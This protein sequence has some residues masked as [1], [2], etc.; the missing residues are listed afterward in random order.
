MVTRRGHS[1]FVGLDAAIDLVYVTRNDGTTRCHFCPNECARTFIDAD[2]P[3]L[4]EYFAWALKL[5]RRGSLIIVDNVVRKGGV[6]EAASEDPNIKGVRRFGERL[7]TETRVS[8][9]MVQTVGAKGYDGFA[10][11]LVTGDPGGS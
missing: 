11:V 6:T 2:R 9:T 7:A 1:T 8:A 4:T 10:L 3:N 5:S